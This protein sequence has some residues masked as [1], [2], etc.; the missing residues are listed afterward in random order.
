M[1]EDTIKTLE[2]LSILFYGLHQ[3]ALLEV[4]DQ[5]VIGTT[6]EER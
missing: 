1:A 5:K 6:T 3:K 4:E 2:T